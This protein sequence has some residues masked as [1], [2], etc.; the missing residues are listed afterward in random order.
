MAARKDDNRA[1]VEEV[2]RLSQEMMKMSREMTALK[3]TVAA[4]AAREEAFIKEIDELKRKVASLARDTPASASDSTRG[5]RS[6]GKTPESGALV[7]KN[8]MVATIGGM[9]KD[10]IPALREQLTLAISEQI[11]TAVAREYEPRIGV[12]TES[13]S[14][15]CTEFAY[16]NDDTETLRTNYCL[17]VIHEAETDNNGTPKHRITDGSVNGSGRHEIIGGAVRLAFTYDDD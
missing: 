6:A 16:K 10:L 13:I 15:L 7:T 5:V 14:R 9:M 4:T 8:M 2:T 1:L 12:L 17:A 3:K 11:L